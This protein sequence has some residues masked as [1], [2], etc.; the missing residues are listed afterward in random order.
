[1]LLKKLRRVPFSRIIPRLESGVFAKEG[2]KPAQPEYI[3]LK[4]A[5][6]AIKGLEPGTH[7]WL[8]L[9]L[10]GEKNRIVNKGV[11]RDENNNVY[12]PGVVVDFIQ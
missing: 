6:K 2:K 4:K 10:A 3:E 1:M 11:E 9:S 12:M 8:F 7:S 5:T